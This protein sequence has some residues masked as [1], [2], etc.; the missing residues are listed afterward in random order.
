MQRYTILYQL[1]RYIMWV[2][3]GM[4]AWVYSS[5]GL[6]DCGDDF[7]GGITGMTDCVSGGVMSIIQMTLIARYIFMSKYSK[8][9]E[10]DWKRTFL[11]VSKNNPSENN[12]FHIRLKYKW[13]EIIFDKK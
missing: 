3:E 12:G 13:I 2:F 6:G 9:G 8:R 1:V 7:I 10:G 5:W 11:S 4:S